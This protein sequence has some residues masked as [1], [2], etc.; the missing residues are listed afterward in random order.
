MIKVSIHRDEMMAQFVVN[1]HARYA[2]P[3]QDI[4]CAAISTITHLLASMAEAWR[5]SVPTMRNLVSAD[6]DDSAPWHIFID[7]A[8]NAAVAAALD[9]II[10]AYQQVAEQF[11]QN[12]I[13]RMID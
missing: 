1:G 7:T 2:E 8:G 4:V 5:E 10:D 12:V 6:G 3:G 13:V 11:P 9:C